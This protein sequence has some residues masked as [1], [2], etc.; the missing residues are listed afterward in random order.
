MDIIIEPSLVHALG[1][2]TFWA[3]AGVANAPGATSADSLHLLS[4][5]GLVVYAMP[6]TRGM[7]LDTKGDSG[8][9]GGSIYVP[10]LP[11]PGGSG[12]GGNGS[13]SGSGGIPA[14]WEPGEVCFQRTSL[15]GSDGAAVTNEVVEADCVGGWD[16]FC[17][18]NCSSTVGS[19]FR[20]V[21]P[22]GLI[23]G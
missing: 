8:S 14:S 12:S 4:I 20:T 1:H 6:V 11:S 18:P 21:D 10:L 13:G 2:L 9:T 3:K 23:G 19:T 22:L 16:G 15:V 17:P 5:A 7:D